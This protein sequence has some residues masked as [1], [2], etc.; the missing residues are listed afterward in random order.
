MRYVERAVPAFSAHVEC[1][2]A[3]SSARADRA[4]N[5]IVPDGCPEIIV[6]L[7]DR[8]ERRTGT[9][10]KRQ[11]EAFF[12]GTLTRPWIV[13]N[14][15]RVMT[16]GLRFRAGGFPALFG[17]SLS[18]TA[19]LELALPNILD[20]ELADDLSSRLGRATSVTAR[21]EAARAWLVAHASANPAVSPSAPAI[22]HIVAARGQ[23]RI[24]DVARRLGFTRR[25]LERAFARDLG[26]RP[27]VY[28]RIVRLNAVLARLDESERTKA[29]DLALDAGYFDQAHLLR[30]F[31]L[32]AG[33]S[34]RQRRERDGAMSRHFTRPE[35]LR[36]LFLGD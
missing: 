9:R 1:I 7:G 8:F 20:K 3:I 33:R 15:V 22:D 29:V 16:I 19:D 27:K 12:A 11:P 35:R 25:R 5:R 24:D 13:R 30:D 36:A 14:G 26:I 2:W 34:P 17:K 18:H 31:R 6:H 23:V 28:A 10:W 32:M 21:L 4:E